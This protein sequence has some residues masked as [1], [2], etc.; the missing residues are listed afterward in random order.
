M[1][2]AKNYKK[3]ARYSDLSE[4]LKLAIEKEFYYEAIFIEFAIIEDRVL[5]M[6]KYA[7][8]DYLNKKGQ[9]I[10]LAERLKRIEQHSAF[11]DDYTKKHITSDLINDIYTWKDR[12]NV[13]I[14]DLVN[15]EYD[16]EEIKELALQGVE[17]VKVLNN[18]STL[19]NNHRKKEKVSS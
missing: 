4:R 16:N 10:K 3:N 2:E 13:L 12:R 19:V 18:K 11:Q 6:L 9:P 5:S 15:N 8:V 1:I 7:G 14:H 17:L